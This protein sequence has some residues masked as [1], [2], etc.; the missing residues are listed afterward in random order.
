MS[1][2]ISLQLYSLRD[3]APKD[4]PGILAKVAE[5]G[6]EAVEFA[7]YHGHAASDLRSV[8]DAIYFAYAISLPITMTYFKANRASLI[9]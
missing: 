1:L 9:E 2:H 6:Y 4:F 7:G 8:L 5:M 3:D